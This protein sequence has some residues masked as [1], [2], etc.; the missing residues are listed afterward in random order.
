MRYELA[1]RE[2]RAETSQEWK[3]GG[4]ILTGWRDGVLFSLLVA[5]EDT[6]KQTKLHANRR[7]SRSP[8]GV[9]GGPVE[10]YPR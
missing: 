2:G 3:A 5:R 4:R 8:S 9:I 7:A 1:W 6:Q 10:V